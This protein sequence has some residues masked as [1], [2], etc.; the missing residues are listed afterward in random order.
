MNKIEKAIQRKQGELHSNGKWYWETSANSGKGDWRMLKNKPTSTNSD[1][2]DK[3]VKKTPS[4][5]SSDQITASKLKSG[6]P[7]SYDALIKWAERSSEDLLVKMASAKNGNLQHRKIAY[8]ELVKRNYDMSLVK[9]EGSL[10]ELLESTGKAKT[11]S[12][13][14]SVPASTN[15]AEK[16]TPSKVENKTSKD[17][18]EVKKQANVSERL[19][20]IGIE[21]TDEEKKRL[22][23]IKQKVTEDW[24]LNEEDWRVQK[25]FN[26]LQNKSDRVEYDFFVD[27]MK[28]KSPYYRT[29]IEEI[30]GLNEDYSQFLG[31]PKQRFMISSGGAG[32]GK[33]YNFEQMAKNYNLKPFDSSV[34][35][36]GDR[37]YDYIE[38]AE[39]S[40]GKQLLEILK[41]HS[42]KIIVF[43]DT[44]KVLT[45]KECQS[46]MKKA[47][48]ATGKR[49]VTDPDDKKTNFEFTGRIV[50]MTNKTLRELNS[51][52]DTRAVL[53]RALLKSEIKMTINE[54]I[55]ILESRFH[56]MNFP[57]FPRLEDPKDDYLERE[58]VFQLIKDNRQNIDPIKFTTRMMG[59]M[60][61]K[62]RGA[63]DAN[64]K[65]KTG[66]V[67][68]TEQL[69]DKDTDWK[70]NA[71]ALITKAQY[72]D[73]EITNLND[74]LEKSNSDE[75]QKIEKDKLIVRNR[76][77]NLSFNKVFEKGY[78]PKSDDIEKAENYLFG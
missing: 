3:S 13:T 63:E 4:K 38:A 34:N 58:E 49:I 15:S 60:I 31:N 52:E 21:L 65:R 75:L 17:E 48:S 43:D 61:G 64:E 77:R 6:K 70:R 20:D 10:G 35:S 9:T 33:T 16:K 40:S 46:T 39:V 25:T 22:D 26:K 37:D 28:K 27:M 55:E 18:F 42:D 66:G 41:A 57:Q 44:D 54:T 2:S 45:L 71:L 7:M 78:V 53:S 74:I 8:D 1:S 47:T 67:G 51:N 56:K 32:I 59:E 69:G 73:Y 30:Y 5:P 24:F 12:K 72:S 68:F 14:A 23:T 76:I 62:K 11:D 50:V 36:P 19:A 29:P